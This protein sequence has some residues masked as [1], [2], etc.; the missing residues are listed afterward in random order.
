MKYL[1]TLALVIALAFAAGEK[2]KTGELER[3]GLI[4]SNLINMLS[5]NNASL[6]ITIQEL[7]H[8]RTEVIK[9]LELRNIELRAITRKFN[10]QTQQL[11]SL[12]NDPEL[13]KTINTKLPSS[14]SCLFIDK[15]ITPGTT[16]TCLSIDTGQPNGR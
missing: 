2:I 14:I 16:N 1:Y 10:K 6:E 13:L 11:K 5:N 3:A 9:A 4:Q 8:N 15:D 7:Q 12:E